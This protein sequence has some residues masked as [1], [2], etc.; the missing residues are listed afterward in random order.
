MAYPFRKLIHKLK[1]RVATPFKFLHTKRDDDIPTGIPLTGA[2]NAGGVY[3]EY[4]IL[5]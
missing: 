4:A 3:A 1:S 5:V 2:S